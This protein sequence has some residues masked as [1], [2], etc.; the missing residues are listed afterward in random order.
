[1]AVADVRGHRKKRER[2]LLAAVQRLHE[3]NPM[4]GLRGVRLGIVIPGLFTMQA[5][6]ILEAAAERIRAGGDPEPE[7]MIPLVASVRELDLVKGRI[8]EVAPRGR[9]RGRAAR[10]RTR[11]AP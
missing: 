1:M 7:I 4:L 2:K 9:G 10:S 11:S 3:S 5:R 6:A 8:E